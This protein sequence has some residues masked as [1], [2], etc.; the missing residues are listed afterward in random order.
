MNF[1][2]YLANVIRYHRKKAK[3]SQKA[4]SEIAG[5]GKTLVFDIEKAK[6]TVQFKSILD[7]LKALNIKIRLESPLMTKYNK[8]N[9]EKS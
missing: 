3:L 9:Y 2:D 7:I 6:Q 4:L 5:T 1:S 8:E